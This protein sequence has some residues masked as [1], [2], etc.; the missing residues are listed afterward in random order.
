M[1]VTC[2][3]VDRKPARFFPN[4]PFGILPLARDLFPKTGSHFSGSRAIPARHAKCPHPHRSPGSDAGPL[5]GHAAGAVSATDHQRGR[6]SQR[7]RPLY[8]RHRHPAVLFA[9]HGR[10]CGARRAQA[11]MDPGA[12]HRGRQ[13]RRPALARAGGHRHQCPRHP[14]RAGVGSHHRLHAL[15]RARP[16]ALGAR[17]GQSARGSAGRRSCS[18]ARPSAFSGSG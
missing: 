14:W 10:P 15:A 8:R 4:C 11:E 6:P 5:Q 18:P 7:R 9:A 13:Y 3:R 1:R 17:A 16:A 2:L 12:R